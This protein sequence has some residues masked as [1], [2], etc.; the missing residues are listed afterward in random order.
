MRDW[1]WRLSFEDLA[2]ETAPSWL[3][4]RPATTG[5]KLPRPSERQWLPFATAFGAKCGKLD[6]N[7]TPGP[8]R[9]AAQIVIGL[10]GF[11]AGAP[12]HNGRGPDSVF[13]EYI[14]PEVGRAAIAPAPLHVSYDQKAEKFCASSSRLSGTVGWI[15][16][17][18]K[19]TFYGAL[20]ASGFLNT[21][22]FPIC[23]RG[24]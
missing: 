7:F 15:L 13:S 8:N 16:Q 20:S 1:I 4:E 6:G 17:P 5:R 10:G 11:R 19:H 9:R 3:S 23:C 2:K 14:L 22:T 12:P 21:N 24:I 18:C